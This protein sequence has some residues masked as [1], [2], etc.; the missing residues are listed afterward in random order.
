MRR[1]AFGYSVFSL[2]KMSRPELEQFAV[3]VLPLLRQ[4]W[5]RMT[6]AWLIDDYGSP[7]HALSRGVLVRSSSEG[8]IGLQI[9]ASRRIVVQHRRFSVISSIVAKSRSTSSSARRLLESFG[10][11][12]LIRQSLMALVAGW[13]PWLLD[14]ADSPV[15][16]LRM[17]SYFPDIIPAPQTMPAPRDADVETF[18]SLVRALGIP[19]EQAA[20]PLTTRWEPHLLMSETERAQWRARREHAIATFVSACPD[21]GKG[22]AMIFGVPLRLSTVLRSSLRRMTRARP[23]ANDFRRISASQLATTTSVQGSTAPGKPL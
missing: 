7:E 1:R 17:A 15:T 23:G 11:L 14:T 12:E 22:Q 6:L 20:P 19:V 18:S 13:E 16:Y 10:P 5:P 2:K 3:Q 4:Y 21:F 8:V 9:V